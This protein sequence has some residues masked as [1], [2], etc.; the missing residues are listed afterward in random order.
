MNEEPK[1]GFFDTFFSVGIRPVCP[2]CGHRRFIVLRE[3]AI[4][5]ADKDI[6]IVTCES[7]SCHAAIGVLAA[8]AVW[9]E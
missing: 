8:S 9:D 4:V 2:K 1:H 6:A 7:K 5:N 3:D